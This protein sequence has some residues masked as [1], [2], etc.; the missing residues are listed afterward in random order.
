MNSNI[1][2][3]IYLDPPF[4]SNAVYGAPIGGEKTEEIF[5]DIWTLRDVDLAWWKSIRKRNKALY[6]YLDAVDKLHSKSMK[7]YLIYM[8]VRLIEMQRVLKSSGSI[9]LH[10]DQHASHY[11]KPLMDA[12]FGRTKFRNEIVWQRT[13]GKGLNPTRFLRNTDHIFFYSNGEKP[14]WNQP[15]MDFSEDYGIGWEEDRY[16]KWESADLSG[17]KAGSDEAYMPFKAA[18][19]PAGRAWAPPRRE[20]FPSSVPFPNDYENMG[21]QQKLAILD[22]LSMIHWS[23]KTK[24]GGG[25]PYYKKYRSTLKGIYRSNLITDIPPVK[26]EESEDYPTQK[27]LALLDMLIRAASNGKDMVFDPFCGCATTCVAAEFAGR[28]WVGVDISDEAARLVEKRLSGKTDFWKFKNFTTIPARD[29]IG[30]IPNLNNPREKEKLRDE[31]WNDQDG[32]CFL[33]FN[34]HPKMNIRMFDIDHIIPRA[35]NG[36]DHR[37][38]LQLLCRPCNLDKGVKTYEEALADRLQHDTGWEKRK[39]Q[40][41]RKIN[42]KL[43]F[44]GRIL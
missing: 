10:C 9:Y 13:M 11:L 30:E 33:C 37:D 8:A 44:E 43:E 1:V 42:K 6:T 4:N 15:Y 40:A 29:D 25:R 12:I 26:G 19:P 18:S 38:N 41:E 20:K 16:G 5:K 36:T 3:L 2:D 28:K 31:I 39:A 23:K 27:P 21:V 7:S 22:K 14:V 17:G 34:Q 32:H 24:R 35:L